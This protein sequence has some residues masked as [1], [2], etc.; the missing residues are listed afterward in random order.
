MFDSKIV[1]RIGWLWIGMGAVSLSWPGVP[2]ETETAQTQHRGGLEANM[3]LEYQTSSE[4]NELATPIAVEYGLLDNLEIFVEPVLY[5][6]ILPNNAK[7]TMGLGDLEVTMNY[8]FFTESGAIPSLGVAG[9]VKIPVARDSLIGTGATDY[10]GYLIAS[11]ALGSLFVHAN[12]GYAIVGQPRGANLPNLLSYGLALE[13]NAA[14][15]LQFVAEVYGNTTAFGESP[16]GGPEN[17][18]TPEAAGGQVVGTVGLRYFFKRNTAFTMGV[19][20]D[21]SQAWQFAPGLAATFR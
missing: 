2:L 3:A 21:N 20:Y 14:T 9:E 17:P 13:Q 15:A 1:R 8:R 18:I 6:A 10:T 11:K 19:S 5:T 7:S 16:E 4:G 12:I